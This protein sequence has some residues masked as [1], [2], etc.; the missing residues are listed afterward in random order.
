MKRPAEVG[1]TPWIPGGLAGVVG[2]LA[3]IPL[4]L[5]W[6]QFAADKKAESW[7]PTEATIMTSELYETEYRD[8]RSS[9]RGTTQQSELVFEYTINGQTYQGSSTD[10]SGF[11]SRSAEDVVERWPR[12]ARVQA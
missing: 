11:V 4:F 1:L 10:P 3:M 5:A 8:P 12:G 2:L 9:S 7:Q 6:P